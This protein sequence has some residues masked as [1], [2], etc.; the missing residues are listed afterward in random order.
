M[1]SP[2]VS[3]HLLVTQNRKP[4][5]RQNLAVAS[6]WTAKFGGLFANVEIRKPASALRAFCGR[7][8]SR[9]DRRL[10]EKTDCQR[11]PPRGHSDAFAPPGALPM[12]RPPIGGVRH[13]SA[14]VE[15]CELRQKM[16]VRLSL[17]VCGIA[18]QRRAHVWT[19][20]SPVYTKQHSEHHETY[21][22]R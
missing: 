3:N 11:A 21:D 10:F 8:A 15:S 18:R 19:T 5:N 6:F 17:F 7:C 2:R 4:L 12:V 22:N 1:P 20:Q 9:L 16:A 14:R 13:F